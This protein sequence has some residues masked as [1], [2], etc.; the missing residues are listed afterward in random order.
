METFQNN[1]MISGEPWVD[2]LLRFGINL[3]STFILIR[4][5]YYPHNNR[6]KYLFTFFLMGIMLFL[7]ASILDKVELDIGLAFGLFAIFGIIRYR[8]PSIDLKE[9]T[10]LFLVIGLAI[11]NALVEFRTTTILGLAFSNM[12]VLGA[13]FFMEKYRPRKNVLKRS[14]FFYPSCLSI[15]NS[16][17]ALLHEI[18]MNTGIE[19][20]KVEIVKIN[21]AKNEV[22]VQIYFDGNNGQLD[23][24]NGLGQEEHVPVANYWEDSSSN[25]A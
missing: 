21:Q 9:M 13:T 19:V 3:L 17:K 4:F 15:L 7:I 22:A 1:Y 20:T 8:S 18:K 10:Y 5:I 14:L 23:D 2:F 25:M 12:V 24:E 6:I 16:N 11:I